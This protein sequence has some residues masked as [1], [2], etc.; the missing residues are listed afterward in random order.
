MKAAGRWLLLGLLAA[1]TH[2]GVVPPER[3]PRFEP[4]ARSGGVALVLGSG[5]HRGFAH[6]GV[7]RALESE[8]LK[9]D[10]VVGSS[11]GALVGALY[12]SGLPVAELERIALEM[13]LADLFMEWRMIGG[14]PASGEALQVF[15]NRALASKP[16]E[17]LPIAFGAVATRE[18]DRALVVFNRGDTG[19]AVRA[20][21]A[22][23]GLFD[24][25]KIG[26]EVYLDGDEASPVPILAARRLGAHAVIAVDVSAHASTTPNDVPVAWIEKDARRARQVSAESNGADVIL[27]PDL[28]YYVNPQEPGR[29][30]AMDVAERLTRER[31]AEIRAVF[32]RVRAPRERARTSH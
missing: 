14:L 4:P 26:E 6:I 8:G 28:G 23:P 3:M 30:R 17:S 25:V 10:L 29:R 24:A 12:A 18:R 15:V 21:G 2:V 5:G 22:S 9:P 27:H 16:I 19:L 13:N 11:V 7:L 1:C 20:S 32:A 31:M